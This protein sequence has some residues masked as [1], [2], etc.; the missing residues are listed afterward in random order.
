MKKILL[1]AVAILFA[2]IGQSQNK[3][4]KETIKVDFYG[5][6][7]SAVNVVGAAETEEKF[8]TAFAAIN[9]LLVSEQS[10]YDVGKFL[11]FD[12]Q[13]LDID[14]AVSQIYKLKDVKFKDNKD[15]K[16]SLKEV[17]KSYPVTQGK[18]LLIVAKELNKNQN[19]GVFTAVVF[20]GNDKQIIYEQ[21]FSGKAGG[22]GLRNFWAGAL[23]NGL[24]A[25]R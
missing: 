13:S 22:F 24:K 1:F 20:D 2:T 25:V 18:V 4:K 21:E 11:K 9:Q 16:I 15:P 6:D 17:I 3:N 14:H 5:V 23:Y 10:K 19:R 7:F 8:M 12:V